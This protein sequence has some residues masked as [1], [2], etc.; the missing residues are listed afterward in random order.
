MLKNQQLTQYTRESDRLTAIKHEEMKNIIFLGVALL[1][2]VWTVAM[3]NLWNW[4][5]SENGWL[6]AFAMAIIGPVI[7]F[8]N[9]AHKFGWFDKFFNGWN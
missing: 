7:F 3:I 8:A 1:S 6:F 9:L 4:N 5:V 2:L